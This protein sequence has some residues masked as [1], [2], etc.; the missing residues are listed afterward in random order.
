[1]VT[2]AA[3]DETMRLI[4]GATEVT[5]HARSWGRRQVVEQREHRAQLLAERRAARDLKG[6][7]RLRAE[8]PAHRRAAGALGGR[9]AQPRQR[10]V[11][12]DRAARPVRRRRSVRAAVAEALARGT[13]DPGALGRLCE[14][15]RPRGAAPTPTPVRFGEH[16]SDA[17][18]IP[19]DLGGLR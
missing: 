13:D 18:V 4:D 7:D 1:M 19:H 9:R 3:D 2:I 5:R 6:R 10:R 17:D 12:H 14:Q 11:A 16:V 8:V 15:Q